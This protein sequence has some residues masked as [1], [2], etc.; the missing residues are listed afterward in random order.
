MLILGIAAGAAASAAPR[1]IDPPAPLGARSVN[2]VEA[3]DRVLLSW[4]QPGDESV[5][6]FAAFDGES[7]GPAQEVTRGGSFVVNR[8]DVP[9]LVWAGDGKVHAHWLEGIGDNAHAYGIRSSRSNDGGR[10]WQGRG[11]LH[12]DESPVEHGFVS[13]A[14]DASGAVRTFWLD[15]RRM[16]GGGD[17]ELRS[18]ALGAVDPPDSVVLDP[19]VCE[20]CS[21]DAVTTADGPLIVYRDRSSEEIRDIS[22]VRWDGGAWSAP[23]TVHRDGWRIEGC[24]VNGPA[25]SAQGESVA[26]AWYTAA[27]Q[28]PRVNLTFSEDAGAIFSPPI[29]VDGARPRGQVDVALTPEGAAIVWLRREGGETEVVW[30]SVARSG[31][32]GPVVR[33]GPGPDARITEYPKLGRVAGQVV[34]TWGETDDAPRLRA[35]LLDGS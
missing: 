24:P 12:D 10:T 9:E 16:P 3:G 27:E 34:A 23:R 4:V 1:S 7:W 26:V 6:F 22:V 30:R 18:A 33:L 19:R 17:T 14:R 15:G 35:V 20:C 28:S 21:T 31:E 13:H 32:V 8:A 2:L 5:L 11:W 29:V 25:A